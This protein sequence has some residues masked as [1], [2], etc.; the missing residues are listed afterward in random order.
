MGSCKGEGV[1]PRG[2]SYIGKESTLVTLSTTR[3]KEESERHGEEHNNQ[4][5][6]VRFVSP[7]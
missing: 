6:Y 3:V 1:P 5:L 4:I 7:G 2:Q